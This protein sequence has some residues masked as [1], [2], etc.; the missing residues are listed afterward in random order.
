MSVLKNDSKTKTE[1]Q[2]KSSC[3]E[4]LDKDSQKEDWIKKH[5]EKFGKEPNLFDGV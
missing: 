2:N 4:S 5:I 3:H 1:E